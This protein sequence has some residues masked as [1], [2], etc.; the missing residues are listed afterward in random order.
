[1]TAINVQKSSLISKGSRTNIAVLFIVLIALVFS[2]VGCSADNMPGNRVE[3]GLCV[4][5][6]EE[7]YLT[8][9]LVDNI[10][11]YTYEAANLAVDD[12]E[13]TTDGETL[14][15][16]ESTGVGS[17][18][19][20]EPGL[21]KFTVRAY[22]TRGTLLYIGSTTAN[23]S[24]NNNTVTV[25]LALRKEG[26]G[27]ARFKI[28]SK[29]IGDGTS[30][31]VYYNSYD[32]RDGG[33][34]DNFACACDGL[35]DTWTGTV[36][37]VENRYNLTVRIATESAYIAS[38]ITD[39]LILAG[40][41]IDITGVL[42]G[43]E[44][45]SV[46]VTPIEPVKPDGYIEL[47]GHAKAG[48]TVTVNWIFS[49]DTKKPDSVKWYMDGVLAGTGE[50]LEITLPGPGMHN[51]SATAAKGDEYA[52]AQKSLNLCSEPLSLIGGTIVTDYGYLNG[53]YWVDEYGLYYRKESGDPES[54]RYLVVNFFDEKA[55]TKYTY[56]EALALE[57]N[58]S[59]LGYGAFRL[60]TKDDAHNI[61]A[62]ITEKKITFDDDFWTGDSYDSSYSYMRRENGVSVV[63]NTSRARVILVREI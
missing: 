41:T 37:L 51:L 63:A 2:V 8:H 53:T 30:L 9:V 6:D 42:D 29:C 10:A 13:G 56:E 35:T 16:L 39:L 58:L 33:F 25:A 20:I 47:D 5:I 62:A 4:S 55:E 54:P 32:G 40:E 15:V 3:T 17:I 52:S 21:W 43:Q 23:V 45:Q 11:S 27:T 49:D 1:M 14:L 57:K 18:G 48:N 44:N 34:S 38:D 19:S 50:S 60:P 59:S 36:S 12:A 28:T 31:V 22:N 24:K 7:K 26:N 61:I 46:T